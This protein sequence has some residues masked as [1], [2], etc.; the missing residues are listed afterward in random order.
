MKT[1]LAQLLPRL[2]LDLDDAQALETAAV[3]SLAAG[4]RPITSLLRRPPFESPHHSASMVA[5]IRGG[6]GIPRPGAASRAHRSVLS[7]DEQEYAKHP[8]SV[9]APKTGESWPKKPRDF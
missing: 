8:S 4:G 6:S 9:S 2:L 1:M 5:L 7:L 3:H